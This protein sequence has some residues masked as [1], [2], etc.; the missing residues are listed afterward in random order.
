M[1]AYLVYHM[2]DYEGSDLAGIFTSERAAIKAAEENLCGDNTVIER[3]SLPYDERFDDRDSVQIAN[4]KETNKGYK[5]V[6]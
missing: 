2:Y 5:R 4:W 6:V 1:Y 3:Y